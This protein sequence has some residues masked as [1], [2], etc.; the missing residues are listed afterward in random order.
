MKY[1]SSHTHVAVIVT[2]A[3]SRLFGLIVIMVG[4]PRPGWFTCVIMVTV[5]AQFC[6]VPISYF[7]DQG[8]CFRR[9]LTLFSDSHFVAWAIFA[10]NSI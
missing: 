7:A 6:G 1:H 10:L 4:M 9:H 8:R 5:M 3:R 2:S